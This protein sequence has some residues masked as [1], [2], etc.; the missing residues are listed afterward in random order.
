MRILLANST[1]YPIIGGVENS[2]RF[3]G[4]ELHRAGHEAKIFCFQTSADQ[5][6]RCEHEGLEIIRAPYEQKR[7]PHTRLRQIVH[8]V[9]S[10]IPRVLDG[11][12]PDAVWSRSAPVGL[13]IAH[14]GFRGPLFQ[15]FCTTTRMDTRGLY[16]QTTGMPFPRRLMLLGLYPLH[17][18]QAYRIERKLLTRCQ[19]IVFSENMLSQLQGR[20]GRHGQRIHVIPPGVDKDFFSPHNGARFARQIEKTYGLAPNVPFV[21]YVGRFS[22]AKNIPLLIDAVAGLHS[23]VKLV[24]V[25][26]GSE[27]HRLRA[28]VQRKNLDSRVVF[29]GMQSERLPGF[30]ALAKVSV[31]PTTIES[32]GQVYLESL[33]CGTPV[34]G[35]AGHGR[36][37][38]TATDEV[39]LDG[40]TGAI[41]RIVSASALA[42]KIDSILYLDD[43]G[44]AAM[45]KRARED[46]QQRFS[47]KRFVEKLF[48]LSSDRNAC[49]RML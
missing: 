7:W 37:V 14:S 5:P 31:L 24:L 8:T 2:L 10:T 18:Q 11:F 48:A 27:E 29:A 16:L 42:E 38:Q 47:W 32:F 30:Y 49:A 22:A 44:Y 41:A 40:K 4:R 36:R 15:I 1:A 25:G 34:V 23:S 39:I 28:Y 17:Y 43:S 6:L 20:N 35:F 33:A 46:V 9:I 13:G 21:L 19:P 26:S 45:S 12:K 3:I